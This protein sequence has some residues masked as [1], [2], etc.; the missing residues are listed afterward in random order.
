MH[1]D[2][3][4]QQRAVANLGLQLAGFISVVP[5]GAAQSGLE[6]AAGSGSAVEDQIL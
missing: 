4:S 2:S 1:D 6:A 3:P 5:P